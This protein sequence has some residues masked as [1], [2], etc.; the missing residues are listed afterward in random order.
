[1]DLIEVKLKTD[2]KVI[3]ETLSRIGIAN[4]KEKILFPSCYLYEKDDKSYIVHFK[5][6]FLLERE[7]AY[8]NIG[9]EDILRRNAIIYCLKQ[10]GLIE[11]DEKLIE[12]HNKFIFV[13]GHKA[14]KEWSIQHKFNVNKARKKGDQI[15]GNDI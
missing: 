5:Q 11:V 10:W 12:P 15:D 1:M 6:L 7:N 2:E 8:D 3:K 13:L 9:P 14:K 4:K